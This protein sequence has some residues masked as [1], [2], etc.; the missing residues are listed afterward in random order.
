MVRYNSDGGAG[1]GH[2]RTGC[3]P[4]PLEPDLDNSSEG[5]A[6]PETML[7]PDRT[8]RG[9]VF[10]M[11]GIPMTVIVNGKPMELPE[12]LSIE[13]LLADLNVRRGYNP[14]GRNRGGSPKGQVAPTRVPVGAKV[15]I[16]PPVGG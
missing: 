1:G 6:K 9:A 14:G 13:G 3:G 5:N 16:V 11:A 4:G 12:G 8:H 2:L 10:S 15:E 7:D